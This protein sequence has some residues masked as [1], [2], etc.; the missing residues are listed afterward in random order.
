M[1]LRSRGTRAIQAFHI[2]LGGCGG[3]GDNVDMLLR[4]GPRGHVRLVEC[5]SPRH[6]KLVIIT[7]LWN[8]GL[9]GAASLVAAQAPSGARIVIAGDCALGLGPYSDA[10]KHLEAATDHVG[11]DLIMSGCPLSLDELAEGAF[12]VAR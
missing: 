4:G 3:C 11:A 9:S 1:P 8:P 12:D 10:L 2:R 6:A 7:G 5:G